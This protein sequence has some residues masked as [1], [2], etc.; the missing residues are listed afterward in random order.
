MP[1]TTEQFEQMRKEREDHIL[2]AGLYLFATKGYESTSA[3]AISAIVK[4]SHGLL[5]H[6]YKSKEELYQAVVEKR[7]RPIV[8]SLIADVDFNQK[9][10]FVFIDI[11]ERFLK[12][13]K[14]VNDEYAWSI[15]LMLDIHLQTVI[16]PKIKHIEKDKKVYD[17]VFELIERGKQ[18][19]DFN[20]LSSRELVIS[21][22]ALYKGL[23]YNRIKIG[24][25]KFLSPKTEIILN[26]VL[27]K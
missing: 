7:V 16:N 17:W 12:A 25:A 15:A 22:L 14:S 6:Y 11:T 13:L 23:S 4:C 19:G 27:K 9:A 10:K 24:H 21:M 18:E 5:Y 1:R 26:M 20:D 2:D 3:D 8:H